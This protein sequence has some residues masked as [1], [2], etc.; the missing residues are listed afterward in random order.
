MG[1]NSKTRIESLSTKPWIKFTHD[2]A[3]KSKITKMIPTY[4][5]LELPI[6]ENIND[7]KYFFWKSNSGF[8]IS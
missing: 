1:E 7:K 8:W 2:E 3:P 6:K 5:L 4:K